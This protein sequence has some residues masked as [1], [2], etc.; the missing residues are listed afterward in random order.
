[1][2]IGVSAKHARV[3]KQQNHMLLWEFVVYTINRQAEMSFCYRRGLVDGAQVRH[4]SH[5]T[6]ARAILFQLRGGGLNNRPGKDLFGN[7]M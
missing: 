2:R 7:S 1:M 3:G 6:P 5:H 4:K